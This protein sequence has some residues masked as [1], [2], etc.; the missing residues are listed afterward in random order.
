M[1][2]AQ[3]E[4]WS[5]SRGEATPIGARAE[6]LVHVPLLRWPS[7]RTEAKRL[8]AKA[9][10][11]LLLVGRDEIPPRSG[12]RFM[13]WVRSPVDPDELIARQANLE[14]RFI[15]SLD[16][17]RPYLDDETGRLTFAAWVRRRIPV[18]DAAAA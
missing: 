18:A 1:A 11:F 17:Q 7:E 4:R 2:I 15:L 6:G 5:R 9:L 12:Y 8:E 13:D 16:G 14:A 10:P 3:R